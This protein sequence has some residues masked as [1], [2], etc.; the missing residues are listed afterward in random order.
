[1]LPLSPTLFMPHWSRHSNTTVKGTLVLGIFCPQ[2]QASLT[3]LLAYFSLPVP[4]LC[5]TTCLCC[6]LGTLSTCVA[7]RTSSQVYG[8]QEN[9]L[10]LCSCSYCLFW[11]VKWVAHTGCAGGSPHQTMRVCLLWCQGQMGVGDFPLVVGKWEKWIPGNQEQETDSS[12][13]WACH[14]LSQSQLSSGPGNN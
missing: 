6:Q 14:M 10:S 5:G 8:S 3:N 12:R 2:S 13:S 11:L 7:F 9:M 1:M 4:S